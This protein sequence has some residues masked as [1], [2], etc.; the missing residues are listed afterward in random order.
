MMAHKIAAMALRHAPRALTE[1]EV[2]EL[3]VACVM[4]DAA[5][6]QVSD[7]ALKIALLQSI[8]QVQRILSSH[9]T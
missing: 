9:T 3:G 4:M 2:A 5:R 6:R 1:E 7:D 8:R